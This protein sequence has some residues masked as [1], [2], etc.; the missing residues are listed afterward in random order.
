MTV[1]M[2]MLAQ[3]QEQRI[4]KFIELLKVLCKETAEVNSS[5]IWIKNIKDLKERLFAS[6]L[7]ALCTQDS[8]QCMRLYNDIGGR[9]SFRERI[10]RGQYEELKQKFVHVYPRGH[11]R[12]QLKVY[13]TGKDSFTE[14][15]AYKYHEIIMDREIDFFNRYCGAVFNDLIRIKGIGRTLAFDYIAT[16]YQVARDDLPQLGLDRVYIKDSRGP[17]WGARFLALGISS[18]RHRVGREYWDFFEN[19]LLTKVRSQVKLDATED[20]GILVIKTED[21]LCI[22]Q[23]TE[24]QKHALEF[25]NGRCDAT[26]FA[27]KLLESR[28]YDIWRK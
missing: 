23:K 4:N 18:S 20:V 27:K 24:F 28:Y 10:E 12:P 6:F 15:F 26:D 9:R 7:W 1:N 22:F 19:T 3:E 8:K 13:I 5:L 14:S 11:I 25:F 16:V 21:L 17:L 2:L